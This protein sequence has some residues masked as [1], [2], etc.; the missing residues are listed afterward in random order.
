MLKKI[1][2]VFAVLSLVPL[3][4]SCNGLPRS[5][6]AEVNGK[7]ITKEDLDRTLGEFRAQYGDQGMPQEGTD[8]YNEFIK[9]LVDGLVNQEIIYME[10][11]QMDIVVSDEEIDAKIELT[12]AQAGGDEGLQ[13]ALDQANMTMDQL[14]DNFR[15]NLII[16]AIYP[17]V[18]KDAPEVTDE[19]AREYYDQNQEMF[20]R[21][22]MRKVSHILVGTQEEANLAMAR[23]DA[24]EDF[25]AVATEVST[26]PGS[27]T[28]GGSLGEVPSVGSGFVPE[29]ETAM[30]ALEV[31]AVSD[32]VQ[33][34]FGFHIIKVEAITPP[35]MQSFEEALE[36][37]KASLAQENLQKEFTK[38]MEEARKNYDIEIAEEYRLEEDTSTSVQ[39][40]ETT[41]TVIAEPPVVE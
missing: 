11:E 22:E 24:G 34:Q 36:G 39:P 17:E 30:N 10:A 28:Q 15:K 31:G 29:F 7:V 14:R 9:L 27:K 3:L 32:P 6:V 4:A 38:W 33:S 12:K 1:I 40:S 26:D 5:A 35:G 19:M 16:E 20:S 8:E 25:A 2:I 13:D 41:A 23:L 37:L 21:P 18:T